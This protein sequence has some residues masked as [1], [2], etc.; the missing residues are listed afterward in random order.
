MHTFF[1]LL[2]LCSNLV[3]QQNNVCKVSISLPA[4]ESTPAIHDLSPREPFSPVS[5]MSISTLTS[6]SDESGSPEDPPSEADDG[7]EYLA[8]GNMSRRG[9]TQSSSSSNLFAGSQP[10]GTPIQT[11][12]VIPSFT[13]LSVPRRSSFSEGQVCNLSNHIKKSHMRSR[14]DTNVTIGKNQGKHIQLSVCHQHGVI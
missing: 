8:I 5:E 6:H 9:S 11:T 13:L 12:P 10:P 3:D 2:D 14:S 4:N 1:F 7:P